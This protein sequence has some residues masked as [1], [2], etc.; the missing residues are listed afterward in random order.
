MSQ[1][2]KRSMHEYLF[3]RHAEPENQAPG[4]TG[5]VIRDEAGRADHPLS[6]RGRTQAERAARVARELGAEMVLSSTLLRAKETAAIIAR[7]LSLSTEQDPDLSEV[8]P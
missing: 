2:S 3:F 7:E 1:A 5:R 6:Q 4:F 8:N